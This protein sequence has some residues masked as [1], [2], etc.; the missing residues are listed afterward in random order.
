MPPLFRRLTDFLHSSICRRFVM[1][2]VLGLFQVRV[3]SVG[4][5]RLSLSRFRP[6]AV[7]RP[8]D[9]ILWKKL[10]L[11]TTH[12]LGFDYGSKPNVPGN[13]SR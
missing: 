5:F 10:L 6:S 11:L 13:A 2:R 1:S 8:T 3:K 9:K 12:L 7:R 4:H